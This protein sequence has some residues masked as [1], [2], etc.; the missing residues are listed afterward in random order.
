MIGTGFEAL[1][2]TLYMLADFSRLGGGGSYILSKK[3]YSMTMHCYSA[4]SDNVFVPRV[5][6]WVLL[7]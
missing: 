4:I 3:T 2:S 6:V 7:S 5:L 1:D